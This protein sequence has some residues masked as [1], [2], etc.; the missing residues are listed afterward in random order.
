MC[1]KRF[2]LEWRFKKHQA[3][4]DLKTLK[5]C[6]YFNN[7][8][9]CPFEEIGCMFLHL[10]SPECIFNRMCRKKMC[11]YQHNNQD[12]IDNHESTNTGTVNMTNSRDNQ[13]DNAGEA[14]EEEI[15]VDSDSES[16]DL[17]CDMCGKIFANENDLA[18]HESSDDNCGYGCD[19]CGAYYRDEIH[20]K[21]H[22]ERHCT[23][24]FDEFSPKT[25]LEAHKKTCHGLQ[26]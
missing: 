7:A 18:E 23:K 20:L 9:A 17:E 5:K 6:H 16:D 19:D 13:I 25:V 24:C 4:H 10:L 22:L 11:P 15:H 12:E 3:S 26:Y 14:N 21:M 8:K 2:Q 1:G